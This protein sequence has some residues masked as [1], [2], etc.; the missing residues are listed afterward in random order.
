MDIKSLFLHDLSIEKKKDPAHPS[1]TYNK[2]IQSLISSDITRLKI[3]KIL[4]NS[5]S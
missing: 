1:I 2:K 3:F 5:I 4:P